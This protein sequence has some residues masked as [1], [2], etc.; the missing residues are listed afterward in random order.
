MSGV[1][2]AGCVGWVLP[3]PPKGRGRII[4]QVQTQMGVVQKSQPSIHSVL[5]NIKFCSFWCKGSAYKVGKRNLF[6]LRRQRIWEKISTPDSSIHVIT[7]ISNACIKKKK[8]DVSCSRASKPLAATDH[9]MC[10]R[11][12]KGKQTTG[13]HL[14]GC[15]NMFPLN[16][17]VYFSSC[18]K[19][20]L[21]DAVSDSFIVF[22]HILTNLQDWVICNGSHRSLVQINSIL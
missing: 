22:V 4:L 16:M 17:Q 13:K 3:H 8:N 19:L 1:Y 7:E 5:N 14:S 21:F 18:N 11:S 20:H 10:W 2:A 9:I 6:F 12:P 15:K